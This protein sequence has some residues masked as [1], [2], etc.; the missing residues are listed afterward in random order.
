MSLDMLFWWL[1]VIGI[2]PFDVA[3]GILVLMVLYEKSF[4]LILVAVIIL[5]SLIKVDF[6]QGE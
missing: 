6:K 4:A 5:F 1:Q 2:D 3:V